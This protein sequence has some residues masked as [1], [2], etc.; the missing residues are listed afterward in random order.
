LY[1]YIY[2]WTQLGKT[3]GSGLSLDVICDSGRVK[4]SVV[5]NQFKGQVGVFAYLKEE[6]M[7]VMKI[8]RTL[9]LVGILAFGLGQ[10]IGHSQTYYYSGPIT[11]FIDAE[12]TPNGLGQG[13]IGVTFGT[14]I[15]TLYYNPES[16]TLEVAGSVALNPYNGSF[17]ISSAPFQQPESGSATLTVGDSGS[18]PFDMT[19]PSAGVG[20]YS[21]GNLLISVSGSGIYNGQAFSGNWNLEM[22][23]GLDISAVSPT[24]LIFTEHPVSGPGYGASHGEPVIPGTDLQTGNNDGTYGYSWSQNSIVA[25]AV[26]EPNPLS[27]LALGVSALASLRL[28]L[29]PCFRSR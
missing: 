15:E 11:G 5:I 26:P 10:G 9:Q 19:F 7:G 8:G 4:S 29:P 23:L 1:V 28:R 18:I 17:N 2:N 13:G 12:L 20:S 21:G 14:V 3:S 16:Q 24:S 6:Y 25:V 22:N 27:L